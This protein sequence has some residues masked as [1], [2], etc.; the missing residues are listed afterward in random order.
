[1]LV[2]MLI[3]MMKM[4]GM[5]S[6]TGGSAGESWLAGAGHAL[7]VSFSSDAMVSCNRVHPWLGEA[8]ERRRRHRWCLQPVMRGVMTMGGPVNLG[9]GL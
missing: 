3:M 9:T 5:R 4:R 7:M 1:M 8:Q 2:M 6:P